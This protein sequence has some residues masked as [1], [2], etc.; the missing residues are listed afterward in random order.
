MSR[1]LLNY[2]SRCQAS[3]LC[4]LAVCVLGGCW[5]EVY[6]DKSHGETGK[7]ETAAGPSPHA[8]AAPTPAERSDALSEMALSEAGRSGSAAAGVSGK[9]GASAHEVTASPA[10]QPAASPEASG[11]PAESGPPL[12]EPPSAG[13]STAVDD[14]F[15]SAAASAPSTSPPAVAEPP[16]SPTAPPAAR[17][18]STRRIAWLLGSK[19]SLAALARDHG[20]PSDEVEKW[21]DQS[22]SLARALGVS[23]PTLPAPAESDSGQ[24]AED[25]SLNYLFDAG[26]QVGRE[27]ARRYGPDHAALVELA[28]K[29]N[30]LLAIYQ[31][32]MSTT[33]AVSAIARAGGQAGLP[34][35]LYQPLLDALTKGAPPTDVSQAVFRLHDAVDQYLAAPA[36]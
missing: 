22:R 13:S 20:A 26:Q 18:P 30:I 19:W 16:T 23:L 15:G 21:F 17:R 35:Q 33:E 14:L 5:E 8:D 11:S 25:T 9:Q 32:G 28:V 2:I 7:S 1:Y 6:Y 24:T 10:E 12:G 27:L 34:D 31:P 29:S 4:V 3:L 36:P